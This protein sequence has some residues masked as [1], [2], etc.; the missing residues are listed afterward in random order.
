MSGGNQT[1]PPVNDTYASVASREN[2]CL[3]LFIVPF[4][5]VMS[6]LRKYRVHT[7]SVLQQLDTG[8]SASLNCKW[9]QYQLDYAGIFKN[10]YQY[11]FENAK[12]IKTGLSTSLKMR[13]LFK[14]GT[15]TSL[16]MR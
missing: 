11:Q 13:K 4:T 10:R 7:I 15:S 9:Y 1:E 6:L 5:D 8:S 3:A 14:T 2:S 12:I 16:R